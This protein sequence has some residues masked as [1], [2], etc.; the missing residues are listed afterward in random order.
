PMAE[1]QDEQ[2]QQQNLL[3]A[4]LAPIY[5][6]VK[7]ATRNFKIALEKT[8]PDVIYKVCLEIIEHTKLS[9]QL[10]MLQRSI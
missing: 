6:H 5:K 1:E 8:Q 2:Q 9:L 4:E 3:D 10:Q 7:I